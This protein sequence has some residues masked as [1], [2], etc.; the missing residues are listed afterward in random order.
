VKYEGFE[1]HHRLLEYVLIG[2][3]RKALELCGAK[4]VQVMVTVPIANGGRFCELTKTW[5]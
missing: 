1:K 5:R 4:Q 2:F 3:Y